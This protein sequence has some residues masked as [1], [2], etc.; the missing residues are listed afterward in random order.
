MNIENLKLRAGILR[1]IRH[2]FDE[3]GF[4]EVA[5]PLLSAEAIAD[6]YVE[7]LAVDHPTLP[8]RPMFLQT[9]PE[10][11]MKRLLAAGM[12][13]IYQLGPVFRPG[14]RGERHNVEFTMLEWYRLGDDYAAGRE[15]LGEFLH[16]ILGRGLP[17]ERTFEDVFYDAAAINPHTATPASLQ[18]IADARGIAYPDSFRQTDD[19]GAWIDLLFSE[20]VQPYLGLKTPTLV[21]DFPAWQS[22]LARTRIDTLPA[23]GR[24]E[25]TQR[26]EIFVDGLELANG[27]DELTDATILTKRLQEVNALRIA[28]GHHAIPQERFL[29]AMRTHEDGSPA[30]PP[31]CGCALG[32]DRLLMI[33]LG[34]SRI[35]DVLTFPIE[36]A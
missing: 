25:I 16:E 14:D 15:F 5:T 31:C 21:Y 11:P 7:P 33:M 3:R 2:F 19:A 26:F 20:L 27:Y 9:S 28:D 30:L 13:S 36:S 17:D 29:A 34:A 6:R 23:N 10:L 1:T 18:A 4:I 22:Q 32:V 8:H 35:D 12:E 24:R